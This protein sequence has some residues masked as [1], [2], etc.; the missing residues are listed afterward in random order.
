MQPGRPARRSATRR[1]LAGAR[2]E[3]EDA[4]VA[5]ADR[6]AD[7]VRDSVLEAAAARRRP[8]EPDGV[9]RVRSPLRRDDRRAIEQFR[10]R[11]GIERRRHH[12]DPQV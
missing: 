4:A 2:K 8:I 3:D 6:L 7:E 12:E 1:I 11:L 5:R 9:H 10:H